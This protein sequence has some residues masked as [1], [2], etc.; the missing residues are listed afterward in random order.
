EPTI[1]SVETAPPRPARRG[2]E[3]GDIEAAPG[4]TRG[5]DAAARDPFARAAALVPAPADGTSA[6]PP[7][8]HVTIGRI[9]VRAMV[10]APAPVRAAA[11]PVAPAALRLSLEQYLSERSEG[12]R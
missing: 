1:V 3:A 8:V 12:R 6:E 2:V 9:E 7:V 10:E 5:R 11:A 4:A